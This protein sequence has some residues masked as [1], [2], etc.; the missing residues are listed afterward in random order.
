MSTR[1]LGNVRA[2]IKSSTPPTNKDLIWQDTSV[3]PNIKKSWNTSTLAWEPFGSG[4]S[5]DN[6]DGGYPDSI[7]VLDYDGGE[8]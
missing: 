7:P 2:L 4:L 5:V 3:N 1:N 6:I 8:I